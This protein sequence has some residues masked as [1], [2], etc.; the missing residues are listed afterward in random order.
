MSKK[1][2]WNR[3]VMKSNEGVKI[4]HVDGREES[5]EDI[6]LPEDGED[7]AK[8]SFADYLKAAWTEVQNAAESRKDSGDLKY[9]NEL[10]RRGVR[11]NWSNLESSTFLAN[12]HRCIAAV[13]KN[14]SVLEKFL[15]KQ[16]ELFRCHDLARIIV[17][18]D[19]I[20]SEWQREKHYLSPNMVQAVIAT[21]ELIKNRGWERFRSD[22]LL[23]P[24]YPQTENLGD[25]IPARKALDGLG[26]VGQATAWYLIRNLYGAPVFKPDIHIC[27]IAN[28]FFP[29]A[30]DPLSAMSTAVCELWGNVCED[31]RFLP[32]HLGEVDF[33]LWWYRQATG[34]PKILAPASASC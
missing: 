11:A 31:R 2:P 20:W 26:M 34:L 21:S 30:D 3:F 19:L 10:C 8:I 23:L 15:P 9:F 13:N 28:Y 27:A 7:L 24:E 14:V 12:Y 1:D 17:E 25:W 6:E 32:V 5:V 16:V 33:I 22:F 4:I 18:Q 29:E